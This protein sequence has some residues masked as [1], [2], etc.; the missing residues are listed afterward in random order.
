M[1]DE[2]V[3]KPYKIST[4]TAVGEILKENLLDLANLYHS[5]SIEEDYQKD[6][7]EYVE[8]ALGADNVG[9]K[10]FH[11]KMVI[12]HRRVRSTK[13]FDSQATIMLRHQTQ[14]LDGM[15]HTNLKVFKNGRVQ[16]T[17]L[18]TI[19]QGRSALEYLVEYIKKANV[20]YDIISDPNHL[21]VSNLKICMINS[22]FKTDIN[23]KR[24][25]LYNIVRS[26][27]GTFCR[28]EP[29]CYAGVAI[30][31]MMN[32]DRTDNNYICSCKSPCA[33]KGCGVGEGQCKRVTIAV[34]GSGSIIITGS[35]NMKQLDTAYNFICDIIKKHY[36]EIAV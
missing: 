10:G 16:M 2:F 13:R 26:Q 15:Y 3:P 1:A 34:F 33:G 12:K 7:F 23:I 11:K 24:N 6:G 28:Y 21:C 4:I 30:Q 5:I 19:E 20:R 32:D 14:G 29:T 17:G 36:T 8:Y 27:Y 9:T 22:D 35:Q 25:K 31:P 18:K